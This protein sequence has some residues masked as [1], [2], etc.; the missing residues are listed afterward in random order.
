MYHNPGKGLTTGRS[1]G[2]ACGHGEEIPT[3]KEKAAGGTRRAD[4]DD[5]STDDQDRDA[6]GGA[7]AGGLFR[8][9]S[10]PVAFPPSRLLR[11]RLKMDEDENIT[12]DDE[13][14]ETEEE[15]SSESFAELARIARDKAEQM[16]MPEE[17]GA[18]IY[19]AFSKKTAALEMTNEGKKAKA[20]AEANQ[21]ISKAFNTAGLLVLSQI[22]PKIGPQMFKSVLGSMTRKHIESELEA[23]D[24]QRRLNSNS[25]RHAYSRVADDPLYGASFRRITPETFQI[26][27]EN[28]RKATGRELLH[29]RFQNAEGEP[30]SA[31]A[32]AERQ[33][34]AAMRFGLRNGLI[35]PEAPAKQARA[36]AGPD[37]SETLEKEMLAMR[38]AYDLPMT[39][40][41]SNGHSKS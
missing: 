3:V 14:Q 35:P 15:P 17:I 9:G 13:V 8:T 41:P 12:P 31:V 2:L 36:K 18:R 27:M 26:I 34:R 22:L 11:T 28:Y 7:G 32:N 37:M 16:E 10:T 39:P 30:L 33:Y 20:L 19:D 29:E 23:R 25:Y 1:V 6:A 21:E 40:A 38:G 24:N 4:P 5:S